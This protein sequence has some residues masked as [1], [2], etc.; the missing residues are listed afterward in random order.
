MHELLPLY[1]QHHDRLLAVREQFPDEDLYGPLLCEPG[2]YL[3]QPVRLLV[4]GQETNG[5]ACEPHDLEGQLRAYR[6]FEV[7]RH[8][9]RSPF[10]QLVREV[11]ARLGLPPCSCAWSNLNRYDQDE[12]PPGGA[13]L[14]SL[15]GL[16]FLLREE[17]SLLRPDV[18]LFFTNRKFDARLEALYPGLHQE[19]LAGLPAPD[20]V[21]LHHP[22][23]PA[24]TLRSPHP[25]SIRLRQLGAAFLN[26]LP[27]RAA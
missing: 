15:T 17:I 22:D 21:R 5:W 24:F 18:C 2:P 25:K 10:W 8:W 16:D 6:D 19:S 1:R 26:C 4:I 12:G 3:D 7:G 11:E 27:S 13:V 14:A 20:V 9:R 23:L